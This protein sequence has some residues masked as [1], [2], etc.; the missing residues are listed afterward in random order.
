[1][2]YPVGSRS[3]KE[4][5]EKQRA[6]R[7]I[8]HHRVHP[9]LEPRID[10][11]QLGGQILTQIHAPDAVTRRV[12]KQLRVRVADQGMRTVGLGRPA[13]RNPQRG[14]PDALGDI[15]RVIISTGH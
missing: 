7:G 2:P 15:P 5:V 6:R 13:G 11:R 12:K 10:L 14:R 1:L 9:L 8:A 4:L 3:N